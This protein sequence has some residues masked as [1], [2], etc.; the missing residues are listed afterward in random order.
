VRAHNTGGNSAYSGEANATTLPNAPNAP[1]TLTAT[2]V[3]Q[4]K[5]DLAWADSSN[6][7]DGFEIERKTLGGTYAQIGTVGADVTSYSDSTGLSANTEYFYR[8]RSHNT[9]GH[10]GYSN[11]ANATTLPN[12]PAAPSSLAA[13]VGGSTQVN[14]AWTDNANN[15][16]GFKIEQKIGAAGAYAEIATVGANVT[17]YAN[18]D[19]T[20]GVTYSY[21]VRAFNTGGNSAYSDEASATP[22]SGANFALNKPTTASSTD[23]SSSPSKAVDASTLTFWRSGFVNST[24]AIQWLQVE[25]NPSLPITI[26]RAVITWNQNYFANEYEIQVSNDGASWTTVYANDTGAAGTQDVTFTAT[27]AR[28]VRLYTKKNNK[29]NYRVIEF[30][31]YGSTSKAVSQTAGSE[32]IAPDKISLAQNYPNPFNPATTISFA[33]PE[34]MHVTLKIINIAGQEVTTLVN[35]Y[36]EAGIHRVTFNAAKLPSGVYIAVL[37]A[38]ET[39]QVQRM[40]LMK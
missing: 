36:R 38:G 15:E 8:V 18:T 6:N 20:T 33:L 11:E 3:S 1:G 31:I 9:G 27:A 23:T 13:T 35:G 30:E 26:G 2:T 32:M 29:S 5:I 16:T 19:L 7:E 12:P 14:L 25:L 37:K 34:G 10:S 21:R 24:N 28:Y 4:T 17:S 39:T 22:S 40:T